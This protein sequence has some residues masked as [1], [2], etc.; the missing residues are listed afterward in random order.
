MVKVTLGRLDRLNH[1]LVLALVGDRA[2]GRLQ[3]DRNRDRAARVD[4]AIVGADAVSL[5]GGCLHLEGDL[6]A[7]RVG[8]LEILGD[9]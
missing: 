2:I 1:E 4:D 7:R 6:L 8:Q 5:R 3:H 9:G